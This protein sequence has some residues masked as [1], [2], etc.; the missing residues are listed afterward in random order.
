MKRFLSFIFIFL[1]ILSSVNTALAYSTE[2]FFNEMSD[3]VQKMTGPG[4]AKGAVLAVV[5]DG[6]IRLAG[7]GYADEGNG[8][9]AAGDRTAFRIGSISKTF[10][11]VAAQIL[12][13]EGRLNM[14]RNIS[15][16]LEPDF[17]ALRYPV[18]MRRLLTHT[19]GFEDML[20]GIAVCNVSDT[21]PLSES[22]RKYVP[23]QVFVPGTVT[24]YSNYGIALAAYVIQ[25]IVQQDFSEFC[26]ANIFIPLH[27]TRTTFEYMHDIY[28]SKPYL[29][30]GSETLEPFI[31]LYPEGSAVSTAEDMAKYMKWLLDANDTRII[32]NEMKKNIF[33]KHFSM[34]DDLPGVGLTWNRKVRNGSLYFDKKGET[35]NFYSRIAL[36]PDSGTGVFLSFNTYLPEHEISA[37]INAAT[38]LL[39]GTAEK[40][41]YISGGKAAD[42]RGSYINNCT[43]F[44]TYEKILSYIV[45]GKIIRITG[46]PSD[47]FLINGNAMTHVGNNMYSST[48]GTL[49][50]LKNGGNMMIATESAVT[51]TRLSPLQHKLIRLIAP[52]F[53]II[54]VLF[55]FIYFSV[56]KISLGKNSAVIALCSAFQLLSFTLICI[57][58][59]KGIAEY[60]LLKYSLPMKISGIVILAA[61]AAGITAA[62]KEK[63]ENTL[64]KIINIT[65]AIVSVCFCIWMSSMNII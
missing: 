25:Q 10:A 41:S 40:S 52:V 3:T 16:Y 32:S 11:A 28:V 6:E 55:S 21:E 60:S 19:A 59:Y 42:I 65:W 2:N 7:F 61:S 37:A 36:Y 56:N 44:T 34:S 63:S 22:V 57:L 47:G 58:M 24:S 51:F 39:H 48:A 12:V 20:T 4:K 23:E 31:N 5:K 13:Q 64:Q 49:K 1:L 15:E 9:E 53:F 17:P 30:G 43:S 46:S 14:D 50:F 35:A 38:D 33:E 29:P 62:I 18:T 45:P 26:R 27:M 8:I 54:S